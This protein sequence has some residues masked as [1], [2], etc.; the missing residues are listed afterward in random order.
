MTTKTNIALAELAEKGA[1]GDL[2]RDMIQ[3]V[4]QWL[5]ELHKREAD[6]RHLRLG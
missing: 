3:C 4:T 6:E 2:L 1:D 5:I